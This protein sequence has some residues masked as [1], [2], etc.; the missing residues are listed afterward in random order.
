[1]ALKTDQL[2][3]GGQVGEVIAKKRS[4]LRFKIP[5]KK[6]IGVGFLILLTIS[7]TTAYFLS[8]PEKLTSDQEDQLISEGNKLLDLG[9]E[10]GAIAKYESVAA[11]KTEKTTE[12][13]VYM[14]LA[15]E[16]FKR[17]QINCSVYGIDKHQSLAGVD[18]ATQLTKATVLRNSGRDDEYKAALQSALNDLN[19]KSQ[20]NEEQ[21]K[22]KVQIQ[23]VLNQ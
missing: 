14:L 13:N 17:Q 4:S 20:L 21:Q 22:D 11:N 18:Y 6:V 3:G 1:M 23:K 7:M 9:D 2:S 16:C 10:N 19:S 5:S 8:R 12:A 15:K